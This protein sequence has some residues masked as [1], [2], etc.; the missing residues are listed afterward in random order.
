MSRMLTT[1]S[2][3]RSRHVW[4]RDPC[5]KTTAMA[6]HHALARRLIDRQT[7]LSPGSPQPGTTDTTTPRER[8][9]IISSAEVGC[10]R[11]S[12][13]PT[14]SQSAA[15]PPPPSNT[16]SPSL[17]ALTT[18]AEGRPWLPKPYQPSQPIWGPDKFLRLAS[19]RAS[20]TVDTSTPHSEP[21]P[22]GLAS[23][24]TYLYQRRVR[25]ST[26]QLYVRDSRNGDDDASRLTWDSRLP[27]Q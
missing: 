27:Q 10:L 2:T 25:S 6:K 21:R 4:W 8:G 20:L 13:A 1:P 7:K 11:P 5:Q 17:E 14:V 16:A 22:L 3:L 18:L 12:P 19:R 24:S 15:T 9:P 26:T 23:T